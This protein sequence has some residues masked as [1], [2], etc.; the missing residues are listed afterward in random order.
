MDLNMPVV[1]GVQATR[2]LR[3]QFPAV[4]VLVLTTYDADE[5]VLDAIRA[6]ASGYL[7]KDAPTADLVNAIEGTAAGKT[8]VDAGI[9]GKLFA[10]I[11]APTVSRDTA[12]ANAFS[13]RERDVL[14]LL[15]QGLSNAEIAGQLF[16][17]EGTIRNYLTSIFEKLGV[18]DRAKAALIAVRHGLVG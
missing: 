2:A 10:Q 16:L 14:Q 6:G 18:S 7:L 11:A 3:A 15:A 12:L 5:W 9:A 1:T 17:S 4:K 8:F 13:Q